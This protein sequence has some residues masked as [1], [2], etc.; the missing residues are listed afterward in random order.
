MTTAAL[1]IPVLALL[2]QVGG[3]AGAAGPPFEVP[4]RRD[5]LVG[6]AQGTLVIDQ[7]EIAFRSP[8]RDESRRWNYSALKQIR[9]LSATRIALDTYEDQGR[10]HLG[11]DRSFTFGTVAPIP[12]ELVAFLLARVDRPM[13][14][15]VM[16]PFPPAPMFGTQVKH[17]R[18][19]RG[20]EG[21]LL[22][23]E[24]GLAYVTGRDGD[25]RFWRFRDVYAVLMLDRYRLQVLA[26]EGGS[27]EIRT[28][29]FELKTALPTGMYDALWQ[30][31][32]ARRVANE[33]ET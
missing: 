17:A 27:S 25:A 5:G 33:G 13:V 12:A 22:L 24:T 10:L 6:G 19:G 1:F 2:L 7:D 32:N 3:V 18:A 26:Y 29:T 14:T 30:R 4:A 11:R 20:S 8:A 23:Y 31:V 16:P 28:F 9:I 21:A 15:A